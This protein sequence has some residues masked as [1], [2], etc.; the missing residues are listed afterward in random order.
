MT[1]T[2]NATATTC[3]APL[4]DKTQLLSNITLILGVITGFLV[5][6]RVG[7]KLLILK[8]PFTMDDWMILLTT[9][10]GVPSTVIGVR[11][12]A[13][14]GLGRDV[15]TLPYDTITEFGRFFYAM[16]VLYFAQITLLKM[17]LLYFY[18]RIF[19]AK[20]IRNLLWATMAFNVAF[21]T[22]CVFGSIFQCT[23]IS[24]LWE[25]WDGEHEGSCIDINALGWANAAI[26]IALD[27][28]MLAIPLSQLPGLNL[29]WKKK[30]GVAI[31][32]IVGTL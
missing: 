26:S 23:P 30:M 1:V 7:F 22:A 20:K 2:R 14:N 25:K 16:V 29:H 11:G 32:F 12:V 3:H 31:M 24:Y 21:G 17:S 9:A 27:V 18:L 5:V 8:M 4:R 28:W 19:P 13:R 15:W 10:V 6:L